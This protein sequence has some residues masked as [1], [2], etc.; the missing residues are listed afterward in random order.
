[1]ADITLDPDQLKTALKS[2]IMELLQDNKAEFSELI[3]EVIEDIAMERA[4]AEG[5][6]TE[7]VSRDTIFQLLEPKA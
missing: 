3:A 6:T 1:M 2:A 5:T 4:I 7:L